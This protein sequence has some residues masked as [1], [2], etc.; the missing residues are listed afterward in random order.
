M[1][2]VSIFRAVVAL[3]ATWYV[4]VLADHIYMVNSSTYPLWL[5]QAVTIE[6]AGDA[7]I[8]GFSELCG[9]VGGWDFYQKEN[10]DFMRCSTIFT[11]SIGRPKTYL[12]ENYNALADDL[13]TD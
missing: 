1:S 10:G 3:L 2:V 13:I 9:G 6:S 7:G 11:G 5:T 4:A 8:E 12:I